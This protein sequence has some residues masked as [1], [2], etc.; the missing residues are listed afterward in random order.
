VGTVA[1]RA[2]LPQ[3]RQPPPP[4]QPPGD[5]VPSQ[6]PEVRASNIVSSKYPFVSSLIKQKR[7][8]TLYLSSS[9]ILH[10]R[11]PHINTR[12]DST[13]WQFLAQEPHS[14]SAATCVSQRFPGVENNF[15]AWWL[16][17][18]PQG[19]KIICSTIPQAPLQFTLSTQP[20]VRRDS[21]N[22][23]PELVTRHGL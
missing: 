22:S 9:H 4:P 21:D 12:T 19:C 2:P 8:Y 6:R 16:P 17:E 10:G 3:S 15:P 11:K 13:N 23:H 14:E 1:T 7:T 5:C 20:T 18:F